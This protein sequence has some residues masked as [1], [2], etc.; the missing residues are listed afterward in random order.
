MTTEQIAFLRS[1]ILVRGLVPELRARML[2][3]RRTISRDTIYNA[4]GATNYE[5]ATPLRRAIIDLGQEILQEQH[6]TEQN[7]GFALAH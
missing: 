2:M 5:D 7:T 6:T 1:E 4:L 3:R